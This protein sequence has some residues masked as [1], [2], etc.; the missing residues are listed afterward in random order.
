MYINGYYSWYQPTDPTQVITAGQRILEAISLGF[1][2]PKP[3]EVCE[4][5]M[6]GKTFF[7]I[8]EKGH[9]FYTCKFFFFFNSNSFK[10]QISIK[11]ALFFL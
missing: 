7:S 6:I 11:V 3:I 9:P 8:V 10:L 4:I 1:Y 5:E 2:S